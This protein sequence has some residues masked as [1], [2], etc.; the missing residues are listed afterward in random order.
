MPL[1]SSHTIHQH[2]PTP[3]RMGVNVSIQNMLTWSNCRSES[4]KVEI[5]SGPPNML[6]SSKVIRMK[7]TNLCCY[8]WGPTTQR[9]R[10]R[11]LER[12]ELPQ[13][14]TNLDYERLRSNLQPW[15][16]IVLQLLPPGKTRITLQ[17]GFHTSLS[18]SWPGGGTRDMRLHYLCRGGYSWETSAHQ[19]SLQLLSCGSSLVPVTLSTMTLVF[20]MCKV[21]IHLTCISG[22]T[23]RSTGPGCLMEL[24]DSGVVS[25]KSYKISRGPSF[26]QHSIPKFRY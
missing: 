14:I 2:M 13:L 15:Y 4:S 17:L 5:R 8:K 21:I 22:P 23:N 3:W 20:N 26:D 24:M 12:N 25:L 18:R 7:P 10:E 1:R 6:G 19:L 16:E 11:C 9:R